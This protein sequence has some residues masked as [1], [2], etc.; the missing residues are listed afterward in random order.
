MANR[1][2]EGLT[3]NSK[4]SRDMRLF[5]IH[6]IEELAFEACTRVV[7]SNDRAD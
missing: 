4:H 5:I 7:D 1:G 6:L 3:S 2:E